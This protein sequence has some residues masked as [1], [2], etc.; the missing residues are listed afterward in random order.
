MS[1]YFYSSYSE[2]SLSSPPSSSSTFSSLANSTGTASG[3]SHHP[4]TSSYE[5]HHHHS[6][7]SNSFST[8]LRQYGA[9][10]SRTSSMSPPNMISGSRNYPSLTWKDRLEASRGFDFE[11]DMEF[12]PLMCYPSGTGAYSGIAPGAFPGGSDFYGVS[13]ASSPMGSPQ[14]DLNPFLATTESGSSHNTITY[15]PNNSSSAL[16]NGNNAFSASASQ[17]SLVVSGHKV[18]K[19]I[20]I[21]DPSTG[22]KLG[23]QSFLQHGITK[24]VGA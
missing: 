4:A 5:N 7:P 19:G 17:S 22:L 8:S 12:C 13:S 2:N 1:S 23:T 9:Y 6:S 3:Y 15:Y 16:N 24:P 21:V 10:P 11:D 18:R 14:E 20:Q